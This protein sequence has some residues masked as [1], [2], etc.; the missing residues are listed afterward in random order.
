VL[1]ARPQLL[2]QTAFI[3]SSFWCPMAAT[4]GF[5]GNQPAQDDGDG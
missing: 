4:I 5:K 2:T 3:S 1:S